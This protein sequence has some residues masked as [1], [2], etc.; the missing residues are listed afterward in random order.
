[1]LNIPKNNKPAYFLKQIYA[2][3]Q[4]SKAFIWPPSILVTDPCFIKKNDSCRGRWDLCS[5]VSF[6][7]CKSQLRIT[8]DK[9]DR[10]T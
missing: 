3:P 4:F 7:Q 9:L 2:V 1:M 8:A 5:L 10:L 6:A